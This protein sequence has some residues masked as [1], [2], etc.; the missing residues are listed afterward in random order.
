MAKDLAFHE[1]LGD[2]GAIECDEGFLPTRA[3]AVDGLGRP[4]VDEAQRLVA[5]FHMGHRNRLGAQ[6]LQIDPRHGRRVL[7]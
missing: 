5:G 2:G 4:L 3:L 1:V 7:D 6:I